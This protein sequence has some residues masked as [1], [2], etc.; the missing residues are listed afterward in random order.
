MTIF[1][2]SKENT[3]SYYPLMKLTI[4]WPYTNTCTLAPLDLLKLKKFKDQVFSSQCLL[5]PKTLTPNA[6]SK[7]LGYTVYKYP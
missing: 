3:P 2:F 7:M 6:F 4:V 1:D 5:A